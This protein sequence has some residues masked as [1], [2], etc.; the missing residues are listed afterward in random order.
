MVDAEEKEK[1][2]CMPQEIIA[3]GFC[4]IENENLCSMS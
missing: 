2:P 3:H 4:V 1:I